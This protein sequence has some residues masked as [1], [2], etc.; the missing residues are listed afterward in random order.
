MNE[1]VPLSFYAALF[2]VTLSAIS[3]TLRHYPLFPLDAASLAWSNAW[4]AATVVD[5]YGSTLC[6]CGVVLGTADRWW[7][8][9][10]AWALGCCL[11]GSPVACLWVLYQVRWRRRPLRLARQRAEPANSNDAHQTAGENSELL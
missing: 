7:A 5:Y 6:L 8:D 3:W 10:I 4:L 1:L 2:A 11:L 9:G